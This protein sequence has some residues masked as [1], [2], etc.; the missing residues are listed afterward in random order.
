MTKHYTT[1]TLTAKPEVLEKLFE[2][3][4]ELSYFLLPNGKP[5]N[6]GYYIW[7]TEERRL[8]DSSSIMGVSKLFPNDEIILQAIGG[9][10]GDTT[11]WHF[12]NGI[13]FSEVEFE[14]QN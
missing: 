8:I 7:P 12:Q 6:K 1:Y 11:I 3:A 10:N 2:V 14:Q 4:P 9:D 13:M 5:N